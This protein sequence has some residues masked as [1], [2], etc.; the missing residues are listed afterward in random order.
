MSDSMKNELLNIENPLIKR[1]LKGLKATII[2]RF[3]F[4]IAMMPAQIITSQ[5]KIE[6]VLSLTVLAL[7]VVACLL[8]YLSISRNKLIKAAGY[9]GVINDL[10]ILASLVVIWYYS[11]GGTAVTPAYM[12]KTMFTLMTIF[13]IVLNSLAIRPSYIIAITVGSLILHGCLLIYILK[14]S[15]TV[16]S[17]DLLE[18]MLG[19]SFSLGLYFAKFFIIAATGIYLVFLTSGARK[20]IYEAVSLEKS[21]SQLGRYF[22]PNIA[23]IIQK[24]Q[25]DFFKPGGKIQEVAVLFCDIRDFTTLSEKLTPNEILSFLSDYHQILV[26]I[27]FQYK[28][29]IDKFIG[30]GIMAT[31][32]TPETKPDDALRAVKAA[33]EIR[34][35]I[36][37]FNV[38]RKKENKELIHI[39]IGI[40][41]GPVIAGNIGT[42]NRLEYTVIGDTVNT[43]SRIESACKPLKRDLLI[44]KEVFNQIPDMVSLKFIGKV[45]L[46]GK[47]SK[48]ELYSV[49]NEEI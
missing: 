42:K 44:S 22:S 43:A 39:G 40:H 26:S 31:F 32:G 33:L 25:T 15:S 2:G 5:S 36:N 27:I 28:G 24:E 19:S 6:T 17:E 41:Y 47:E 34:R 18:T 29:T 10:I 4:V 46:K 3:I 8:F 11:V 12:A 16:I 30:D 1:E 45:K 23:S 49:E 7:T 9:F 48:I 37:K 14:D 13:L 35:E 20:T 21:N 38:I